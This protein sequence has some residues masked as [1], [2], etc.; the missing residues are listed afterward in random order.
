MAKVE[1]YS[2]GT[3]F[4]AK[5]FRLRGYGSRN[6]AS[7]LYLHRFRSLTPSS[8]GPYSGIRITS[9]RTGR[10]LGRSGSGWRKHGK[11]EMDEVVT[12]TA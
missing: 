1:T 4:D 11:G 8:P 9:A 2:P 12:S 7:F 5:L 3:C 10:A 6:S